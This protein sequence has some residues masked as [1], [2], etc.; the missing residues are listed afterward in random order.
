M[1]KKK[2]SPQ[3]RLA[4]RA[5]DLKRAR[6]ELEGTVFADSQTASTG[7][8]TTVDQ[9]PADQ[10]DFLHTR[11]LH[12]TTERILD[13]EIAQIQEAQ[14]RLESGE[15]GMCADCGERIPPERL[16][17]RPEAT[18]CVSCQSRREAAAGR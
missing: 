13:R 2:P 9:H 12:D 15:Y 7:E 8:L 6:A 16:E 4:E 1:A 11:E 5:A 3:D 17:A 10:A 18:L 14:Q